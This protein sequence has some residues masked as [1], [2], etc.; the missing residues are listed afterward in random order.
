MIRR[1]IGW[2]AAAGLVISLA[3]LALAQGGQSAAND[4][5]QEQSN[6]GSGSNQQ[7]AQMLQAAAQ[8]NQSEEQDAALARD[9]SGSNQAM[10]TLADTM[11]GDHR[12]NQA[13]VQALASQSHV[14][15]SNNANSQQQATYDRLNQ[16]SGPQF[17]R[18]FLRE[19]INQHRQAIDQFRQAEQQL[20]GNRDAETYI[21]QTL[22]VLEAHLHMAENLH[23]DASA[24]SMA[25]NPT[26][27][28]TEQNQ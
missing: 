12:A 18:A 14:Q 27:D 9:K 13:A 28:P 23:R 2:V 15:L 26:G 19:E 4:Q 16:L 21:H 7:L 1:V 3:G 25:Q 11:E 6:V 5:G 8:M 17:N 24:G 10:R 20:Q 22:P